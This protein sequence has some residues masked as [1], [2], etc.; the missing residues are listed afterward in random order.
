MSQL[1]S[2]AASVLFLAADTGSG[3]GD[4][5]SDAGGVLIV[6]GIAAAVIA[7]AALG[8]WIVLTRR[9]RAP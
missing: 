5:P 7:L 2:T 9:G 3:R 8:A 6:V 4:N 1:L